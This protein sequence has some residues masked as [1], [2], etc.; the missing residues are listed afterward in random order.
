MVHLYWSE[1]ESESDIAWN[2]YIG[3]Q[4]VCLHWEAIISGKDQRNFRFRFRFRSYIN[5]ALPQITIKIIG[6]YLIRHV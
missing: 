2:G 5:A 4:V 6:K 3:F 1:S